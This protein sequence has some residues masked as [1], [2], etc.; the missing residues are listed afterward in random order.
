MNK[1]CNNGQVMNKS[2]GREPK[3][4]AWAQGSNL[5]TMDSSVLALCLGQEWP[6]NPLLR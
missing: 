3:G 2:V 1:W 5:R 6:F 4:S